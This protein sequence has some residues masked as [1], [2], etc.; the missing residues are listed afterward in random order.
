MD[1][2]LVPL[3]HVITTALTLYLWTIVGAVILHW[4]AALGVVNPYNPLVRSLEEFF[5]RVTEPVLSSL[6]RILPPFGGIDLSPLVAIL[7]IHFLRG[8]LERLLIHMGA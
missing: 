8:M 4:L 2:I 6:R 3:F 1:I 5:E 7:A